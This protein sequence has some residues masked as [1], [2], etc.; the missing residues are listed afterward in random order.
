MNEL[1]LTS[2]HCNYFADHVSGRIVA[3]LR[4]KQMLSTKTP[5]LASTKL[6]HFTWHLI[7]LLYANRRSNTCNNKKELQA[8]KKC[9]KECT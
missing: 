3:A 4:L 2:A 1:Y 8:S 6:N 5:A 7:L 9:M